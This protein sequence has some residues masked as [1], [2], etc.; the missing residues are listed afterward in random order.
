MLRRMCKEQP[1]SWDRDIAPLLFAYREV[2]QASIGV[3]ALEVIYGNSVRGPETVLRELWANEDVDRDKKTTYEHVLDL[4]N[5]L[6]GTCKLAH[7]EL[8][9][10]VFMQKEYFDHKSKRRELQ[11]G[12]KVPIL[13]PMDENKV[14]FQWNEPLLVTKKR[15]EVDYVIDLRSKR[16]LFH[17]NMLKKYVEHCK[18]VEQVS[19]RMAI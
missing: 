11:V 5:R 16:T 9:R 8:E 2:P 15:N 1:R 6:E 7:A 13:L 19:V 18:E 4:R 17:I 14:I 10:A 3:F 12:D